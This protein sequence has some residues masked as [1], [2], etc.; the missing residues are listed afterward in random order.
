MF[1]VFCD[2]CLPL[3]E[4]ILLTWQLAIEPAL[5]TQLMDDV[6]DSGKKCPTAPPADHPV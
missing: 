4:E 1:C 5:Q 2:L 3:S 6:V